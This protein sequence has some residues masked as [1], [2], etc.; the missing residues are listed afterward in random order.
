M[1]PGSPWAAPQNLSPIERHLLEVH[2]A[3][4]ARLFQPEAQNGQVT[5]DFRLLPGEVLYLELRRKERSPF[6]RPR[7]GRNWRPGMQ[8]GAKSQK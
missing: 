2:A 1:R 6:P 4:E 3:P 7:C 8:Q 5:H